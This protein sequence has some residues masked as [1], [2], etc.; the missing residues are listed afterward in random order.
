MDFTGSLFISELVI[1]SY[2]IGHHRERKN[3]YFIAQ[4]KT[5][6][7]PETPDGNVSHKSTQTWASI[8]SQ[9]SAGFGRT[10]IQ[11]GN[12]YTGCPRN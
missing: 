12:T 6:L 4:L 2:C 1:F 9:K 8:F 11:T 7:L 5:P 3:L 10:N